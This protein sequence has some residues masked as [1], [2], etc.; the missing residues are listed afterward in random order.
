V[1]VLIMGQHAIGVQLI[2]DGLKWNA[3]VG[4]KLTLPLLDQGDF[5]E[6]TFADQAQRLDQQVIA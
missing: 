4:T 6:L 5:L 1:L 3:P 2:E